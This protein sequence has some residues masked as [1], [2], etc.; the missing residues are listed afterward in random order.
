L[1]FFPFS[2]LYSGH[3]DNTTDKKNYI[4]RMKKNDVRGES[5]SIF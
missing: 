2:V 5:N 1:L 3:E 4:D